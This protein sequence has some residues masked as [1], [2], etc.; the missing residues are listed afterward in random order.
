M[1]KC[2]TKQLRYLFLLKAKNSLFESSFDEPTDKFF[3]AMA[4]VIAINRPSP[5]WANASTKYDV[6]L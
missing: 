6:Y 3:I 4:N 5:N 1:E 2:R